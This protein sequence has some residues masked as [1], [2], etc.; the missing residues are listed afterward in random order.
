[1]II[2]EWSTPQ[3]LR[4]RIAQLEQDNANLARQLYNMARY[5][6]LEIERRTRQTEMTSW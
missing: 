3:E 5:K 6:S 1:M 2:N 4:A